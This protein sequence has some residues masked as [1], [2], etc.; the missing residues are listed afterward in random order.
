L[1][2]KSGSVFLSGGEHKAIQG[3]KEAR[4]DRFLYALGIRHVG[5]G[6]ARVLAAEYG[7]LKALRE[8]DSPSL[9]AIPEIGGEIARSVTEFFARKENRRVL[10]R[11]RK[12]GVE[13]KD[14]PA[15]GTADRTLQ[16][17]TFVFTGTL[18]HFTRAEAKE[19]IELLRGRAKFSVSGETD[20]LVVGKE[21]G[22]KLEEAE[23]HGTKCIDEK[24]FRKMIEA[25]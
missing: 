25:R 19:R 4:L 16:G 1:V 20:Y 6:I 17:K 7:S 14:I 13:V 18:E 10:D 12:A 24:A 9:Q 23:E 22:G 2:S 5:N 15:R 11:L 8:A 3:A 21:P